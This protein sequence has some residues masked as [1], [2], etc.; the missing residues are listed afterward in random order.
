MPRKADNKQEEHAAKDWGYSDSDEGDSSD[1]EE[2]GAPS[3]SRKE[4]EEEVQL[5]IDLKKKTRKNHK[6]RVGGFVPAGRIARQ[7]ARDAKRGIVTG[8]GAASSQ[9]TN[10]VLDAQ[11]PETY[12]DLLRRAPG[13]M[14]GRWVPQEHAEAPEGCWSLPG[15][16]AP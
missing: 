2:A 12:L 4:P 7:A 10:D 3:N 1:G 11:T 13:G 14:S 15:G 6:A 16:S 8:A 9:Q 5:V